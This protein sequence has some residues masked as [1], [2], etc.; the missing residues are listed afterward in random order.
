MLMRTALPALRCNGVLDSASTGPPPRLA[1]APAH[2]VMNHRRCFVA[3]QP[4]TK[5]REPDQRGGGEHFEDRTRRCLTLRIS[6][7]ARG[8]QG[9]MRNSLRGLRCMRVLGAGVVSHYRVIS[10]HHSIVDSSR[11]PSKQF[12]NECFDMIR[13]SRARK[14]SIRVEIRIVV[15]YEFPPVL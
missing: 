9:C 6:G 14:E 8:A 2:I 10:R 3:R 13:D 12:T 7:A 4:N 1:A 5:R 15:P 11:N